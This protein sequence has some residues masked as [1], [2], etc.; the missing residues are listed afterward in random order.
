MQRMTPD[1]EG[2]RVNDFITGGDDA[3]LVTGATGFVGPAVVQSLLDRGFTNLRAFARPSSN[4]SRLEAIADRVRGKARIE[5]VTGNLLSRDDCLAATK[6]VA[7]IFHLAVSGENSFP[8]AFMNSVVTTRNLLDAALAAGTLRRFVNVS[9]FA[10]YTNMG[11]RRRGILDEEAPIEEH[12]ELRGSAYCFA[13]VKQDQLVAEY[14]TRFGVPYVIIRPGAV[15]G[16]GKT[17]ITGRVGLDTFGVFL[18]LGGSNRLPLTYVDNCA[19]AIVLAG[20]VGGIDGE[21][22]NVV[23][24]DLPSSRQFLRS[25]KRRVRS[26]RSIYVPHV[27]SYA[28]CSLWEA[29]SRW[30]N[31]QLPLVFNRRRWHAEWRPTAYSNTRVKA[32]LGWAPRVSTRE[33]LARYFE[34][35]REGGDA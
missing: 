23:D 2:R 18:H 15:Y 35:C 5:L 16:P 3:V 28:L 24:D 1:V 20:M 13:K 26:F 21:V 33:A 30:S 9:S 14:G 34:A 27:A 7:V 31:G 17:A 11:K 22:F 32:R 10:V 29:Y 12:G 8:D 19:D 6:D 4:L 25:Y